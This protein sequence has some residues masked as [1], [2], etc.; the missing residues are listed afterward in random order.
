L[1]PRSFTLRTAPAL[2]RRRDP[3]EGWEEAARPLRE[4]IARLKG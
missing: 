1:N 2:M 4:A 3:W